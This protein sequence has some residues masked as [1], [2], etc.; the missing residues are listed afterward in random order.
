MTT[1]IYC[2][3]TCPSRRPNQDNVLYFDAPREATEAGFRPCKRCQAGDETTPKITAICRHI[4]KHVAEPLSLEDLGRLAGWSPAHLQRKFKASVGVSPKQF[5]ERLRM[6]L[7]KLTVRESEAVT[8][9]MY[10]VGFGSSSRLYERAD[11]GLGMTPA[12]YRR[13]GRGVSITY[14]TLETALGPLLLGATDRGLCYLQFDGTPEQLRREYP[15]AEIQARGPEWPPEL[16]AWRDALDGYL[17]SGAPIG[18]LPLDVA[19]TAFQSRVWRYLLRIP[20]G[21]VQSYQQ[22]ARG[23]GQPTAARA[24]ARA[25]ATNRVALV[26]PCHRV[27]RG[28]GEL[29]GYRWGLD[30][31]QALLDKERNASL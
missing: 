22:V 19:G 18:A 16:L 13:G 9:V 24:V 1:G 21:E 3:P 17:R 30:R 8:P 14:V 12:Q 29:G 27:I 31:K 25:C 23:I 28:T 2:A 26:I 20:S 11:A 10:D 5:Q 4:R 7:F 15:Q 6:E